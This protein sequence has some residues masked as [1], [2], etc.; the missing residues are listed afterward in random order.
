VI[1]MEHGIT[2]YPP[3]A[4]GEPWRAVFIENGARR[5]RQA[6][7]E[8]KLARKLEKIRERLAADASN[9][10]RPGWDLIAITW[11]PT[12]SRSPSGGPG[13]TRTPRGGCARCTSPPS[14]ALSPA[15]TSG[16]PT[17]RRS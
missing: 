14:S 3:E 9:R 2:V 8:A 16:R 12:G 4:D 13:S 1:E 7:T 6:A 15:R 11:T 10:E 17:C 5:F